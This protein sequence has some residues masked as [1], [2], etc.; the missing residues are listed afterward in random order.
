MRHLDEAALQAWLDLDRS[1]LTPLERDEI[2]LHL[3][4]CAACRGR[5]E[6]AEALSARTTD[7]LRPP[8]TEQDPIPPYAQVVAR[9][10]RRRTAG[11][12]RS[13]WMTGGWAASLVVALGVGWMANE[14]LMGGGVP[15]AP[16]Q[17]STPAPPPSVELPAPESGSGTPRRIARPAPPP[18]NPEGAPSDPE[19][20]STEAAEAPPPAAERSIV[21]ANDAA[22]ERTVVSGRVT[23]QDGR[24]LP[25]AQVYVEGTRS[26]TLTNVDGRFSILLDPAVVDAA[27][28]DLTLTALRIGYAAGHR[29]FR[30]DGGE[31][32]ANFELPQEALA[33]D[34]IV[35]TGT[36]SS[37]VMSGPPEIVLAPGGDERAWTEATRADAEQRAGFDLLTVPELRV[38]RIQVEETSGVTLVRVVQELEDGGVLDLVEA[39]GVLRF[40]AG[41]A[42]DGRARASI[43]RGAISIAAAAPVDARAL[44]ALLRR[45]R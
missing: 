3:A 15:L 35:V 30:P 33:L 1:G 37:G 34:E 42:E 38:L 17:E 26:G 20:Q 18:P 27:G 28:E 36:G 45:V 7:L 31:V 39:R 9:A 12:K 8:E 16:V 43:R 2:A 40:D 11:K 4:G 23:D 6:E 21:G 19:Q 32:V 41:A 24:P 29:S 10:R 13:V 14:L 25:A 5:L 22:V 44:E